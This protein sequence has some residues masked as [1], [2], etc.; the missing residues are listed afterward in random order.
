MKILM[1]SSECVPYAK[2]GGLADVVSSLSKELGEKGEDVKILIPG[3]A[4]LDR[5]LFDSDSIHAAVPAQFGN[6]Q[7]TFYKTFLEGS[8]IQ[9]FFLAHPYFTEREGMYG[10]KDSGAY[11]DNHRRFVL[12]N[13]SVFTLCQKIDWI[14]DVIHLHDWQAALVPAYLTNGDGG[15]AF[16]EVKSVITIHNIG[17]QGVFSKHDIHASGLPWMSVSRRKAVYS[18]TFNFLKTGLLNSDIITTVSPSYAEEIKTS[19]FG[20]GMEDI[21]IQKKDILFGILNGADY[22]QWNPETDPYLP[23]NF[24]AEDT[25]GKRKLKSLLKKQLNLSGGDDLPLIGM[26]SRLASQKG[27]NELCSRDAGA[28]ECILKENNVQIVILGT[29]EKWIEDSL[30]ELQ[31]RFANLRVII[32]F[33]NTLAHL[34]EAASDYFLMPSRYE[35]CGLNQIYSLRYGTVPIVTQTGGLKDSVVDIYTD[36]E[37]G[38]GFY[39]SSPDMEAICNGVQKAVRLWYSERDTVTAMMKRGM[40]KIFSWEDSAEKYRELYRNLISR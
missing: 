5:D 35:P 24:S 32:G 6:V 19:S 17:Y 18:D 9:V 20:E 36:P 28:L 38:T 29:G 31:D 11:R 25:T 27:F 3:Y 37:R 8:N 14:P 26:V 15:N 7:V 4:S 12:L 16:K 22:T 23:L 13:R 2:T 34:I 39:L 33:D 10:D 21:L 40:K 1:V 30:T